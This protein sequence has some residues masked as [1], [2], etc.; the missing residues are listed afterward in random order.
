MLTLVK[1]TFLLILS[2]IMPSFPSLGFLFYFFIIILFYYLFISFFLFSFLCSFFFFQAINSKHSKKQKGQ[3]FFEVQWLPLHPFS[4]LFPSKK[5]IPI[6]CFFFFKINIFF[7]KAS[8]YEEVKKNNLVIQKG[9]A[10]EVCHFF[11]FLFVVT[12]FC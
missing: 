2:L 5:N 1:W 11:F 10:T 12:F 7:F 9:L 6:F 3:L 8:L 4:G